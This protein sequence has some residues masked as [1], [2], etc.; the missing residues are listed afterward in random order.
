[1][2]G[3]SEENCQTNRAIATE[4]DDAGS[5]LPDCGREK[6]GAR[7]ISPLACRIHTDMCKRS[8]TKAHCGDFCVSYRQVGNEKLFVLTRQGGKE[9]LPD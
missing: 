2:P 3:R 7:I 9:P 6:P 4:L 1:M 5:Q 8:C